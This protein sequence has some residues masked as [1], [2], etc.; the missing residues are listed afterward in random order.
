MEKITGEPLPFVTIG[1]DEYC[2]I[3]DAIE[4]MDITLEE[5]MKNE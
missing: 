3:F 4:L 5:G 1:E 2:L